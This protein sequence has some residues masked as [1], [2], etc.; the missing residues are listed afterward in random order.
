MQNI[1]HVVGSN[2]LYL[3]WHVWRGE[4]SN[5]GAEAPHTGE[6]CSGAED[7]YETHDLDVVLPGI[8]VLDQL[9]P[10]A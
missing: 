6:G 2:V 8:L 3:V 4:S 5:Y 10:S 9:L 7:E 1:G